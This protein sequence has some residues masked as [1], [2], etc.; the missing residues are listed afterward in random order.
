MIMKTILYLKRQLRV[1]MEKKLKIILIMKLHVHGYQ[2]ADVLTVDRKQ[3][4]I[5]S[6]NFYNSLGPEAL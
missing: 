3:L 5:V 1:T 4:F 6:I 2:D